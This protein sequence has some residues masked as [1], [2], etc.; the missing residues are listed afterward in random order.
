MLLLIFIILGLHEQTDWM[1]GPGV[2]GPIPRWETQYFKGDSITTATVGQASLIATETDYDNWARHIIESNS[3]IQEVTQGLMPVDVDRDGK[4]DFIA[5]T[6]D[7]VVWYKNLGDWDYSKRFVGLAP[8]NGKLSPCVWPEDVNKDGLIDILA[9]TGG[10]GAG[11]YENIGGGTSWNYHILD[12]SKGYHRICSADVDL[13]GTIDIIAVDNAVSQFY[14]NIHLFRDTTGHQ[15]FRKELIKDFGGKR[16]GFRVYPADFNND[17][18]PD[19]YSVYDHVYIFLNNQSGQFDSVY[20]SQFPMFSG[21][22][23]DGAWAQDMDMDGDIDLVTANAWNDKNPRGFWI[24]RNIG[25]GYTYSFEPLAITNYNDFSDGAI[26]RD[27]DLDGLPDLAGTFRQ[28]GWYRQKPDSTFEEHS[29]GTVT[30][31][32]W[33][34]AEDVDQ[35]CAPDIDLIVTDQGAHI[36]YENRM[37]S[38]FALKGSLTSSILEL[39]A[40]ATEVERL[41]WTACLP[42]DSTLAFYWRGDT[43]LSSIDTVTWRGPCYAENDTGSLAIPPWPCYRYFQYKVEF[44]PDTSALDIAVL[45]SIWVK[46]TICGAYIEE[47]TPAQETFSLQTHNEKI[48]LST[49]NCKLSTF[50]ELS[51]YNIAGELVE[52]IYK[53]TISAGKYEFMP[54]LKTKG[55]YLVTLKWQNGIRQACKLVK[56]K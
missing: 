35:G 40:Q 54:K 55:V 48:L 4:I 12:S 28:V 6:N 9:A 33:I 45:K 19:I 38:R 8:H 29:I 31:S 3:G 24:H 25:Y 36:V 30:N 56:I 43:L 32:H 49:M 34:Y 52:T 23:F 37:L 2:K 16:E 47:T 20:Y 26:A 15:D 14:G 50:I 1:G 13:N 53:G 41:G 44:Y 5:H 42:R 46:D 22:D 18:Y 10:K 21:Y 51:I 39:G 7:S 11:W 17:G 27:I